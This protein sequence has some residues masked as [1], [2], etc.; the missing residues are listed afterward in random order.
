MV[1]DICFDCK[2]IPHRIKRGAAA[3]ARLKAYER[4]PA[5]GPDALNWLG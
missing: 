5:T 3:F 2:M 1:I 4:I